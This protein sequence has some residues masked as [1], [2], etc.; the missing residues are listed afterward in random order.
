MELLVFYDNLNEYVFPITK[1]R[2]RKC[3]R[4]DITYFLCYLPPWRRIVVCLRIKPLLGNET[5]VDG[6][7]KAL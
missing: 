7:F 6:L 1:G 4:C 5:S 3:E 2:Y